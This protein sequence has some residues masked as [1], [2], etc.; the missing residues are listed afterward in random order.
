MARVKHL[1][2]R[3]PDSHK[4][5]YGRVLI[6]AGS[7]GM[8]GAAVLAGEA[9]YRSGAGLVY[10]ACPASIR[11]VIS[12]KQTCGV[13]WA[14]WGPRSATGWKRAIPS[15]SSREGPPAS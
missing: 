14:F 4:G 11:D 7:P 1:P 5:D 9:A 15:R 13:V 3:K 2:R 6:V 12:I 10:Y 8:C